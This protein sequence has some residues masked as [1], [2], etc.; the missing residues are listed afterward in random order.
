MGAREG[1]QTRE[2]GEKRHTLPL[3]VVPFEPA[4]GKELAAQKKQVE[5]LRR[6]QAL[7]E[8]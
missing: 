6:T 7:E 1:V 2:R 3:V 4:S 5:K 8:A